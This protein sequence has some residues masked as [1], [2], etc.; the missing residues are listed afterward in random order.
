VLERYLAKVAWIL[1]VELKYGTEFIGKCAHKSS[2]DN[3]L[4]LRNTLTN[5]TMEMNVE[6]LIGA[7]GSRSQVRTVFD[8][9][10]KPIT[11]I[12]LRNW[13]NLSAEQSL[14]LSQ[15]C[16]SAADVAFDPTTSSVDMKKLKQLSLLID[17]KSNRF[18]ND[19]SN[20][21]PKLKKQSSGKVLFFFRVFD[22]SKNFCE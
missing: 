21:C 5:D 1:G 4:R 10:W 6:L 22:S 16:H 14:N 2:P 8:F 18:E 12:S 9:E 7:D 3:C 17:F 15:K 19:D 20:F 13:I 11:N